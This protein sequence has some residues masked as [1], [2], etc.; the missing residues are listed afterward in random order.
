[1]PKQL[2]IF[3]ASNFGDEVVQLFRDMNVASPAREWEIVGFLDDDPEKAGKVRD[4]VTV[5]G[6]RTWLDDNDLSDLYFVCA[7]GNPRHKSQI[8]QDLRSKGARFA[9]GIHPSVIRSGTVVFGE[10]AIVAAGN[11]LTTNIVVGKHVILN[12]ACTVGHN[13]TIGDYSTVNP[14]VNISGDITLD[15]GVFIGT[16]ACVLEKLTVGKYAI[17][18]A[19][20]VVTKDL[21]ARVTAFGV[22][23]R[24]IRKH[25]D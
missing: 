8:V 10:G 7:I 15:E 11:I 5:L 4:G 24:I 23:S 12:L 17:V 3:G 6:N 13:S 25:T 22:P 2:V 1:M 20:A 9:T 14:G 21:P 19:G 18:G 16:G